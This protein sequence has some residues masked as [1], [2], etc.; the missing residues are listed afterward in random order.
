[1][2][3]IL[4]S[5]A[6]SRLPTPVLV[7][8]GVATAVA[9]V[10]SVTSIYLQLKNYRQPMLQR[11]VARIMI[12]VP[13]YAISSLIALFSLEAAFVID[14][15]RDI[16]E[17]FVIYCFFVLLLSYLGGERSLLILLHGRPPKAAVFPA[18]L[19]SREI[20]VSDP[21]TFLF[22]KRG[23]LRE[24]SISLYIT[25]SANYSSLEYVQVKPILAAVTLV[26]KAF[27][28]FNE[29]DLTIT[30][31]GP[32]TDAEHI[33]LG[34]T[35]IL[36]CL[37][38]PIFAFA[39][40]YAFSHTD[41]MD[42][43]LSYVA[44][45]PVYY[46]FRDAFGLLDVVEDSR[47]TLRGEGMDYREFE[48]AEGVMH[49]GVGRDR[50]IRA[51]L[52]YSQGG[53]RKYW[54]PQQT[55]DAQVPGR[56]RRGVNQ[57]ISRIAGGNYQD[58]EV[59]EPLF[60]TE[61][62]NVV[63]L[64]P[65]LQGGGEDRDIWE[66]DN[67]TAEDGYELP[68]GDLNEGDEELF[69]QSK[70]F[71]FGDYNYP[72]VDVS[73]ENA[74]I[75]MWDEEE[76]VL[77]DERHAWFS[78][79]RGAKGVA[80]RHGRN[81]PLWQGYGA[82]GSTNHDRRGPEGSNRDSPDVKSGTSE[83]HSQDVRQTRGKDQQVSVASLLRSP[84]S[85]S[86]PLARPTSSQSSS[87]SGNSTSSKIRSPPNYPSPRA[88]ELSSSPILPPDAV[89]L[90]VEDDEA[91]QDEQMR[92]RRKGDPAIRGSGLR[93]VYKR[94]FIT[95]TG[96]GRLAEGQIEVQEPH[97]EDRIEVGENL[98]DI[99]GVE[100]PDNPGGD[101]DGSHFHQEGVIAR[102]TTPPVHAQV[103]INEF[104]DDNPWA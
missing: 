72:V 16:Y 53:Q 12:M 99:M 52:R 34:L 91:A 49:Q 65:D 50:R 59:R 87:G 81:A 101:V 100:D 32:Y 86:R 28:K 1:M 57:A 38:M 89:D 93:K 76:R 2:A 84:P 26:L 21:Y 69:A 83:T 77:R 73:S 9:V 5:G 98:L 42:P 22:L 64:A 14:A 90:V 60:Q 70:R 30:K 33:S 96:D 74:R 95:R 58:E 43:T 6:G 104:D 103:L 3:T 61:A 71:L 29:G 35:D 67:H 31:L 102:A 97:G 19:F 11:M 10:V 24:S 39:H 47:A 45:M 37:E 13:I 63:H 41:Y 55:E 78:P 75:V 36:I 44:R 51:G 88:K 80:T 62:E 20:D 92:E 48:P 85:G 79:I 56:F 46:A 68:F 18:S 66:R 27:G 4:G 94:G 7:L 25:Q 40:M 15:I 8:S 17:A 54:L 23:I 82:V